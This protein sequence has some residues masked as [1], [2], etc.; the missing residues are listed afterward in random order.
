MAQFIR[1][2]RHFIII[3]HSKASGHKIRRVV[4]KRSLKPSLDVDCV[5]LKYVVHFIW[6]LYNAMVHMY[7]S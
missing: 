6:A 2:R 7:T 4:L 3:F 5:L 1:I